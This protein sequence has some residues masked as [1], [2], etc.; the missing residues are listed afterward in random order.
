MKAAE[1]LKL[2]ELVE[3]HKTMRLVKAAFGVDVPFDQVD[4]VHE[5]ARELTLVGTVTFRCRIKDDRSS[6]IDWRLFH[7]TDMVLEFTRRYATNT[8]VTL[9][10]HLPSMTS[11]MLYPVSGI[12]SGA[13]SKQLIRLSY[14]E[15]ME[16]NADQFLYQHRVGDQTVDSTAQGILECLPESAGLY[17]EIYADD[18]CGMRTGRVV[19]FTADPLVRVYGEFL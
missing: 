1:L 16:K 5:P 12:A 7:G 14:L 15:P 8:Q 4:G 17:V 6:M 2:N 13:G 11:T 3:L 9:C 10:W 18:G 19:E